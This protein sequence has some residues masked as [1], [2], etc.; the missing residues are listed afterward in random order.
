MVLF[1]FLKFP[2]AMFHIHRIEV[3]AIDWLLW[4]QKWQT[5]ANNSNKLAQR[6]CVCACVFIH[7]HTCC[8]FLDAALCNPKMFLKCSNAVIRQWVSIFKC[9]FTYTVKFEPIKNDL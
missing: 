9:R 4:Q 8:V 2:L 6:K 7:T 3:D 5:K 1:C